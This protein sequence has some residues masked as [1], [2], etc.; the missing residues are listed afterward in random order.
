MTNAR[1]WGTGIGIRSGYVFF[2]FTHQTGSLDDNLREKEVP[3]T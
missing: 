2:F 3:D 1:F